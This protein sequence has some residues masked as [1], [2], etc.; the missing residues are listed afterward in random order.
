MSFVRLEPG[1]N[2]K[3]PASAQ[4]GQLVTSGTK[5]NVLDGQEPHQQQARHQ[6][7]R[8]P[9]LGGDGAGISRAS[10]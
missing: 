10:C 1:K 2:H 3:R 6:H 9:V 4:V 5:Q 8:R 7:E